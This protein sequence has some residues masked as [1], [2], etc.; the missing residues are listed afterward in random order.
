MMILKHLKPEAGVL[1]KSKYYLLVT[2][3]SF[4]TKNE[5]QPEKMLHFSS[6]SVAVLIL[7]KIIYCGK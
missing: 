4:Q 5:K 3:R 2:L 1:F 7:I 6:L